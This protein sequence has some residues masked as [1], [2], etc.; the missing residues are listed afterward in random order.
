[1]RKNLFIKSFALMALSLAALSCAKEQ[2]VG[3]AAGVSFSVEVPAE[4]VTRAIGDGMS[5]TKLYY[6]AFNNDGSVIT[7]LDVQNTTLV[8]GTATVNFQLVKDQTYNFVFWAQ[9]PEDGY[10]TIDPTE[11]LKKIT[12]NYTTNKLANDEKRDAFYA[13]KTLKVSGALN[14]TVELKR[15]FAQLNIAT[16]GTIKAGE[17]TKDIDFTGATSKVTVKKIPTVFAPLGD[18]N[19]NDV[20]TEKTVIFSAADIPTGEIT[21]NNVA[22]KYLAMN[23][24]FAPKD[25]SVYDITAT[26]NVEGKNVSLSAPATPIKRN[27]RTNIIGNL[28]T[29][30]ADFNVVVA[31]GFEGANVFDL[32]NVTTQAEFAAALANYGSVTVSNELKFP[33]KSS[34]S[35]VSKTIKLEST[36][37]ISPADD[38]PKNY[39]E[40]L[41]VGTNATLNLDG[42]G[43]IVGPSNCVES[44]GAA[45]ASQAIEVQQGGTLNIRGNL[46]INGGSGSKANRAI[47]ITCG[48]VN[49]YGGHFLN[50]LDNNGGTSDLILLDPAWQKTVS[51][52]IYGGVFE[53]EGDASYLINL[54]DGSDNKCFVNVYGGTFKGFDP[55]NVN[56]Q[57]TKS[58]VPEGYKSTKVSD[59]PGIGTYV[60]TKEDVTP[61]SSQE[62][63]DNAMSSIT[64]TKAELTLGE[65]TYTLPKVDLTG[66]EV[67]IKGEGENTVVKVDGITKPGTINF[68]NIT[69]E[70]VPETDYATVQFSHATQENYTNCTIKGCIRLLVYESATFKNCKFINELSSGFNGYSIHYYGYDGSTVTIK[71]C[72]FETKQKAICIYN[73]NGQNSTDSWMSFN[74]IV[75]NCTFT[76]SEA[77]DKA[78]ISIHNDF[79]KLKGNVTIT[80]SKAN[81]FNTSTLSPE[82]LWWEGVNNKEKPATTNFTITVD[83]TTVQTST[84]NN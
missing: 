78:A 40:I 38:F 71:N 22:Y 67:T 23:Y 13:V 80:N 39:T 11:G 46:T 32:S 64:G 9:T 51:C 55:A 25:G 62:G 76:A 68:E 83:G 49:I 4:V 3:Q 77:T 50:G 74:L 41:Y 82:G 36:G 65:G 37:S 63:L 53:A 1:M 61:V 26:F 21:V 34:F 43:T 56:E 24:I 10:Y 75:D 35:K 31:P 44:D 17:A 15:P 47:Y 66:K 60:V 16:L 27:F 59:T 84:A 48:T 20:N 58:F 28:L 12:A 81:G 45:T 7:G 33:T 2:T 73:E 72:T 70:R 18:E 29:G 5:A 6:Q 52:N 14:E 42:D 8:N 19:S 57:I 30:N 79:Q 69:M 54:K